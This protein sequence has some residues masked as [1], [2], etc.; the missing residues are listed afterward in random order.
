MAIPRQ[1]IRLPRA[2]WARAIGA[3]AAGKLWRGDDVAR[4]E[5]AF[6]GEVGSG[7]AIAVSS[8]RAG[9][10]G[11]LD[12]LDLP[13][14]SEIVCP[15]FGYPVVP[16]LAR[17]M[18]YRLKFV[19]CEFRTLGMDP[20]ALEAA[21]TDE[22]SAVIAVHLYGVP[23]RIREISEIARRRG[24]PLIE[25]CAHCLGATV[26]GRHVGRFGDVAYFSFET[27][28][29]INTLGGGMIITDDEALGARVREHVKG[30]HDK[31][32]GWLV[33]R[34]GKTTFERVVT[35]PLAFNLG[36]YPALRLAAARSGEGEAFASGYVADHFTMA[37]RTGRYTNFQ[38]SL[39]LTELSEHR[40]RLGRRVANAERLI[41][42]LRDRVALQE[43]EDGAARANYMLV[44]GLFPDRPRVCAELLRRGVDTKHH[45]MR[46]CARALETGEDFPGASRAEAEVLHLPAFPE[47]APSAVDRVAE[48]VLAVAGPG[49]PG[50][51][52][53]V[54]ETK[55]ARPAEAPATV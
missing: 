20:A 26:D 54:V 42:R 18:G 50:G 3:G 19:D 52:E 16:H 33:K 22:T 28:K 48:A 8:G 46:D 36:V 43:P 23:C 37:G 45:Y 27:S 9:L 47:L 25:D 31:T 17:T 35:G 29:M 13:E 2:C 10:R 1:R 49:S 5:S 41:G 12:S 24:V 55:A 15:A 44:T 21:I 51:A 4:F 53:P 38:A 34:L 32:L 30:D 14:G 40:D 11:I 6:A 39:G 7:T